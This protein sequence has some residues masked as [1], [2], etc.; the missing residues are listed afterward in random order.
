M[1]SMNDEIF[2]TAN[3]DRLRGTLRAS[4]ERTRSEAEQDA[5]ADT[6]YARLEALLS[7]LRRLD[8]HLIE[9]AGDH[10]IGDDIAYV[11]AVL[12]PFTRR[13]DEAAE[14]VSP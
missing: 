1:P 5:A 14:A 10:R 4:D 11:R 6:R 3:R 7:A 2:D 9:F 13:V 8:G 12:D